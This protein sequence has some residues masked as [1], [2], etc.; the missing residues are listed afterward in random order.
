MVGDEGLGVSTEF[1]II[2]KVQTCGMLLLFVSFRAI[3]GIQHGI[4]RQDFETPGVR[5][6]FVDRVKTV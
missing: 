5:N 4:E 6:I 2:E 1:F 3:L